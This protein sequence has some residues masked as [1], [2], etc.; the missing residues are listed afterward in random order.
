VAV[1]A[2]LTKG[3][4]SRKNALVRGSRSILFTVSM[5]KKMSMAVVYPAFSVW[6]FL[7]KNVELGL[8]KHCL[9]NY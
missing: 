9:F 6:H 3:F 1:S 4:F 7:L 5:P 8:L 2:V